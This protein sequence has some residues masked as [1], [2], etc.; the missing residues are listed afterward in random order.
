MSI[1]IS[2]RVIIVLKAWFFRYGIFVIVISDNGFFFNSE[3]FKIFSEEWDFY[4]VI[5]SFYYV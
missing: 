3:D 1:I 4:Y 5:S 2:I